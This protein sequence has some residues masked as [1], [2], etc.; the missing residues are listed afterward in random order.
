[1]DFRNIWEVEFPVGIDGEGEIKNGFQVSSSGIC[2]YG[3]DIKR[4]KE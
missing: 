1:M 3:S 4:N 2:V